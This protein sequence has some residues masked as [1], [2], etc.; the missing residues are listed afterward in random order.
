MKEI[1]EPR[2]DSFLLKKYVKKYSKGLVL[3]MGTGSGIQGLSALQNAD[4]VISA[5]INKNAVRHVKEEIEK[6][7]I[8]NIKAVRSDLFSYLKNNYFDLKTK[9]WITS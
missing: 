3:D 7:N 4:F 1:Y 2:E 6:N 9:K 5:D 8:D